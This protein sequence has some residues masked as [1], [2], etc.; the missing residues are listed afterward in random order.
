M[1]PDRLNPAPVQLVALC[2]DY[3]SARAD[4]KN[5][6]GGARAR[7]VRAQGNTEVNYIFKNGVLIGLHKENSRSATALTLALECDISS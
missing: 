3:D 5:S 2:Q 7:R 1:I 4:K 6:S